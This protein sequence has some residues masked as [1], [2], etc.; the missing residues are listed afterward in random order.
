MRGTQFGI[1]NVSFPER[2]LER[3]ES[4]GILVQKIPHVHAG[5]IG[6]DRQ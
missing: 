6:A 5:N 4:G 3:V 2:Q 1:E